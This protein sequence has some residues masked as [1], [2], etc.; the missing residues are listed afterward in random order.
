M[1]T[2]KQVQRKAIK[3]LV[4]RNVRKN[5]AHTL[6]LVL[7]VMSVAALM[8]VLFGA[9]ISVAENMQQADLRMKGSTANAFLM[10]AS[11]EEMEKIADL[12]EVS[13]MGWQQFVAVADID[14]AIANKHHVVMTAYDR[15]EWEK[16]ILP[17]ISNV[18]GSYPQDE[19]EIMLPKRTLE[20]FGIDRAE[21]GMPVPIRFTTLAGE[22]MERDF[23]LT[24]YYKDYIDTPGSAPDSGNTMSANQFYLNQ[25]SS[26]RAAGNIVVSEEFAEIYGTREGFM[27]S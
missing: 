24:G 17:T 18:T 4:W 13:E 10:G 26:R 6:V 19:N 14:G 16:H 21:I 27:A 1:Q 12:R 22:T 20:R 8:T 25:G 23:I 5:R 11:P 3:R 2:K 15:T 9:G 7:A